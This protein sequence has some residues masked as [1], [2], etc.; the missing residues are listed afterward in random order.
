MNAFTIADLPVN[1]QTKIA[2]D[3]E[4]WLWTGAKNSKG[5]GSMSNGK[6]GS[7]LAHRAAYTFTVGAIPEG[8]TIDHLCMNKA[9][10]NPGHLEPVTLA[11][12]ISRRFIEQTHCAKGHEFAGTNVRYSVKSDGHER[13]VCNACQR[14]YSA[15]YRARQKAAA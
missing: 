15:A 6:N 3:G 8:L 5:Y 11:E 10:V 13:R 2:V 7:M 9:C 4:C 1:M 12:N 14:E